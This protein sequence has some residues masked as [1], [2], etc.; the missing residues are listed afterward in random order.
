MPAGVQAVKLTVQHV[1]QPCQGMPIAGMS[2]G[3]GPDKAF[4]SQAG[5]HVMITG[6]VLNVVVAD[7]VIMSHLPEYDNGGD[8]Q[9]QVCEEV[10]AHSG[11]DAPLADDVRKWNRS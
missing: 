2:G 11:S 10:T 7:E 5:L 6:D 1:R 8:N 4:E 9:K 3:K